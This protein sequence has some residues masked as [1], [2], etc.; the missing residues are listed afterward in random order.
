MVVVSAWERNAG[1]FKQALRTGI[2]ALLC[3][4]ITK[5]LGL[6]Q[7]YW[8]A[9]SAIIVLQS[10]M[11]ATVKASLGRLMATAIGAVIG[12][13]LVS[14]EGNSYLS[15]AVAITLAILCCTPQ[16]LRDGYR[17]A[18]S[19]VISI[20]FGTKFDSPWATALERFVEVSMGIV[21]ALIVAKALW[22]SHARQQLRKEIQ[23]AFSE[24]YVLFNAVIDRYR[25]HAA[26]L[27]DEILNKIRETGRRVHE[28]RQQAEYE[29]DDVQFPS[30]LIAA[31]IG[32]LRLVRQAVDGLELAARESSADIFQ[33]T[34]EPELEK[35]LKEI[36]SAFEQLAN[37]LWM[38]DKTFDFSTVSNS[39]DALDQRVSAIALSAVLSEYPISD[40]LRFHSFI[41]SLRSLALELSLTGQQLTVDQ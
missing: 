3:L 14:F 18:G 35:L 37:R 10:H 12:A 1:H 31:T 8:A 39:V 22:P 26:P 5:F 30:E 36:S 23:Q 16:R 24:L 40:V 34:A 20:M 13:I 27:I 21:V 11:G 32:H 6:K 33:H 29:P 19:T 25:N 15:V 9:I 2:A 41:V 17:L 38:L 7:G 4:Y 28:L